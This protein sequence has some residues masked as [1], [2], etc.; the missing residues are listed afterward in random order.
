MKPNILGGPI[1]SYTDYPWEPWAEPWIGYTAAQRIYADMWASSY[2]IA[3]NRFG[4]RRF[5]LT[6]KKA[7]AY[8]D[9]MNG[10]NA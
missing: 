9:A 8:C 10:A 3:R 1:E 6:L 4:F 2:K 7:Q 5:F